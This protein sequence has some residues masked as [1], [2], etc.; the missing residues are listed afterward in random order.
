MD[1]GEFQK[2]SESISNRGCTLDPYKKFIVERLTLF[3]DTPAAQMHDW[4]KE[5]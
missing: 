1:T 4:L 5:N 3:Q 2:Y